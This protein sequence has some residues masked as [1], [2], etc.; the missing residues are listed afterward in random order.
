MKLG[1]E[2][3]VKPRNELDDTG[4]N[5]QH[6]G[7]QHDNPDDEGETA[8]PPKKVSARLTIAIAQ[9]V[10]NASAEAQAA[11]HTATRANAL[12]QALASPDGQVQIIGPDSLTLGDDLN[13]DEPDV[14]PGRPPMGSLPLQGLL[15]DG[16]MIPATMADVQRHLQALGVRPGEAPPVHPHPGGT[17]IGTSNDGGLTVPGRSINCLLWAPSVH[18]TY[19]G[20]PSVA[21]ANGLSVGH[22]AAV[23]QA[24]AGAPFG[25]SDPTQGL[26]EVEER[27]R[28]ALTGDADA[29]PMAFVAVVDPRD[30]N[31]AHM[32]AVFVRREAHP[33]NPGETQIVF[34]YADHGS[35]T[36][37]PNRPDIDPNSEISSIIFDHT[38]AVVQPD[39]ETRKDSQLA[40][41]LVAGRPTGDG[42]ASLLAQVTTLLAPDTTA[43]GRRKALDAI[44]DGLRAMGLE[45]GGTPVRW[46]NF[47][48]LATSANPDAE[49]FLQLIQE[50]DWRA[51][52]ERALGAS[53]DVAQAFT[54]VPTQS[55]ART[56]AL[57]TIFA[58]NAA[59]TY[60]GDP[61]TVAFVSA[62][63]QNDFQFQTQPDVS[64]DGNEVHITFEEMWPR[65]VRVEYGLLPGDT[66]VELLLDGDEFRLVL[67]HGLKL[68]DVAVQARLR[69]MIA[70]E[71]TRVRHGETEYR[72]NRPDV[73][74]D[75][76]DV[77]QDF[78]YRAVSDI[79]QA[80]AAN[81]PDGASTVR[82]DRVAAHRLA[83]AARAENDRMMR[84][85]LAAVAIDPDLA[86]VVARLLATE[87]TSGAARSIARL[88]GDLTFPSGRGRTAQRQRTRTAQLL[89]ASLR[90]AGEH[91]ANELSQ[92]PGDNELASI[93]D[94]AV[95]R[96][97]FIRNAAQARM[98]AQ[99][100][101]PRGVLPTS[102][103]D[104]TSTFVAEATQNR[105]E[106]LDELDRRRSEAAE[107]QAEPSEVVL[108]GLRGSGATLDASLRSAIIAAAARLGF[109]APGREAAMLAQL[110]GALAALGG[111]TGDPSTT[112][113]VDAARAIIRDTLA[114][115]DRVS[116]ADRA[117]GDAD[118][119]FQRQI[120]DA[121]GNAQVVA[122]T[123]HVLRSLEH[124]VAYVSQVQLTSS[125]AE[126]FGRPTTGETPRRV[127]VTTQRL[128]HRPT[129]VG[130]DLGLTTP[131]SAEAAVQAAVTQVASALGLSVVEVGHGNTYEITLPGGT[132]PIRVHVRA[133]GVRGNAAAEVRPPRGRSGTWE[134]RVATAEV[135]RTGLVLGVAEALG[136]TVATYLDQTT[137]RPDPEQARRI[138]LAAR[139][140]VVAAARTATPP[141]T[142]NP[143][144]DRL[145]AEA[146]SLIEDLG[147]RLD[148]PGYGARRAEIATLLSQVFGPSAAT[149]VDDL[150][151]ELG[152]PAAALTD[153]RENQHAEAARRATE[154]R[155]E[156]QAITDIL[157]DQ[158]QSGLVTGLPALTQLQAT[159]PALT[160][161]ELAAHLA[162]TLASIERGL[163][164]TAH[165]Q[166]GS[167]TFVTVTHSA[168]SGPI[169]V[170]VQ[171]GV[172][173]AGTG[174]HLSIDLGTRTVTIIVAEGTTADVS[175]LHLVGAL[176]QAVETVARSDNGKHTRPADVLGR[177]PLTRRSRRELDGVSPADV[178]LA[179][180][181]EFQA[182]L[183]IADPQSHAHQRNLLILLARAGVTP[184]DAGHQARQAVLRNLLQHNLAQR[185]DAMLSRPDNV[186]E[187]VREALL[188]D[189][190]NA[191]TPTVSQGRRG[192]RVVIPAAAESTGSLSTP[193]HKPLHPFVARRL[194]PRRA[195]RFERRVAASRFWVDRL[196]T[197]RMNDWPSRTL[198]HAARTA[199][200]VPKFIVKRTLSLFTTKVRHQRPWRVFA[201]SSVSGV[202]RVQLPD[203]TKRFVWYT[204]TTAS[205]AVNRLGG[206]RFSSYTGVPEKGPRPGEHRPGPDGPPPIV[207]F[208][209]SGRIGLD[210]LNALASFLQHWVPFT[211]FSVKNSSGIGTPMPIGNSDSEAG[212]TV[213]RA[214]VVGNGG[215]VVRSNPSHEQSHR[216]S[217]TLYVFVGT[218]INVSIRLPNG[219]VKS[220]YLW[221]GGQGTPV[222]GSFDYDKIMAEVNKFLEAYRDERA[223]ADPVRAAWR[224][225][226][227]LVRHFR[228]AGLD[229][230]W[231]IQ[232]LVF[233]A[234]YSH[235][236]L[237]MG[238]LPSSV[239]DDIEPHGPFTQTN[240]QI[241]VQTNPN[242]SASVMAVSL[243]WLG[244]ILASPFRPIST[245]RAIRA[246]FGRSVFRSWVVRQ[247]VG[248]FLDPASLTPTV[249]PE[250]A[251]PGSDPDLELDV[252]LSPDEVADLADRYRVLHH[253]R[254]RGLALASEMARIEALAE[255]SPEL[256]AALEAAR[257][258]PPLPAAAPPTTLGPDPVAVLL[259]GGQVAP[260]ST[261]DTQRHLQNLGV[262]PGD[263]P[264][265]HPHPG[266]TWL[267]TSNDG[268]LTVPGRSD[269]CLTWLVSAYHTYFG[270][271]S[272]AP[273]NLTGQGFA[274]RILET[275]A[276][277][278]FQAQPDGVQ[279]LA[280]IEEHLRQTLPPDAE[281]GPMA[282]VIVADPRDRTAAHGY[283]VFARREADPDNPGQTKIVFYYA[284]H[285]ST[286]GDV[287]RPPID[288]DAKIY[289]MIFD[290]TGTAVQAPATTR[291][292][293]RRLDH[294]LVAG[295]PDATG[296]RTLVRHIRTLLST[297]DTPPAAVL[298]DLERQ[299]GDMGLEPGGTHRRWRRLAGLTTGS[300]PDVDAFLTLMREPAW[301]AAYL[302]ALDTPDEV[303]KVLTGLP[304]GDPQLRI[305]LAAI[306]AADP[307]P[308]YAGRTDR[309]AIDLV[310]QLVAGD[311]R[312][313]HPTTAAVSGNEVQLAT[314]PTV[315]RTVRVE[316]AVLPPG[317]HTRLSW[318][319]DTRTFRLAI[320]HDLDVTTPEA[321][322]RIARELARVQL[323]GA[324]FRSEHSAADDMFLDVLQA[325]SYVGIADVGH[326]LAANRPPGLTGAEG[327]T[328]AAARLVQRSRAEA[329]RVLRVLLAAVAVDPAAAAT[330]VRL[331][332]ADATNGDQPGRH[333][334][335]LVGDLDLPPGHR[336]GV[337][338][339]RQ[340]VG[341]LVAATLAVARADLDRALT[342]QV[343]E[344]ELPSIVVA[345]IDHAL[346]VRFAAHARLATPGVSRDSVLSA[347]TATF[348][349]TFLT[350]AEARRAAILASLA[351]RPNSPDAVTLPRLAGT[352]GALDLALQAALRAEAAT[353]GF[354][355]PSREAAVL[356]RWGPDL[357]RLG[358]RGANPSVD[359]HVEA[360][361]DLVR[362][363][364]AD[365]DRVSIQDGPNG[366]ALVL[367]QKRFTGP[368]GRTRV[369]EVTIHVHRFLADRAAYIADVQVATDMRIDFGRPMSGSPPRRVLVRTLL[370]DR[371]HVDDSADDLIAHNLDQTTQ[372]ARAALLQAA[373][374]LAVTLTEDGDG[375]RLTW[376]TGEGPTRVVLTVAPTRG[377]SIAEVRP[378]RP[379]SET[380]VI[381][382]PPS[383]MT[384]T[385][386][387]LDLAEALG[388]ALGQHLALAAGTPSAHKPT[389]I[390]RAARL[391]AVAT[392]LVTAS[393]MPSAW[394]TR[395]RAARLAA[396]AHTLIE[397]LG[398]RQDQP[399]HVARRTELT[400]L[401]TELFGDD[402][403]TRV[404]S[405]LSELG[406]AVEDLTDPTQRAYAEAARRRARATERGR[407]I[408]DILLERHRPGL[409]A[410]VATLSDL[411]TAGSPVTGEGLA[412]RLF[413][414]TRDILLSRGLTVEAHRRL[415]GDTVVTV[416]HDGLTGPVT[417]TVRSSPLAAGTAAHLRVDP[418]SRTVVITVAEGM[419]APN[420]LLHL[421][422]AL[423]QALET[424]ARTDHDR[425]TAPADV[426]GDHKLT[427]ALRRDTDGLS[428]ADMALVAQIQRQA[429]QLDADTRP[430]VLA[431]L[432][433]LLHRAGVRDGQQHSTL[434]RRLLL[435]ALPPSTARLVEA[436]L[437]QDSRLTAQLR[438]TLPGQLGVPTPTRSVGRRVFTVARLPTLGLESS[439]SLS[440]PPHQ[441]LQP[442]VRRIAGR[443]ATRLER[444][445]AA[446]RF[447]INRMGSD[448]IDA[449]SSPVA[450]AL[451][452]SILWPVKFVRGR[453][454]ALLTGK[455]R[456]Q[457]PWRVFAFSNTTAYSRLRLPDGSHT[458]VAYTKTTATRAVNRLGAIR[459]STFTPWK[460]NADPQHGHDNPYGPTGVPPGYLFPLTGR[461]WMD[462]IASILN[463]LPLISV[464]AENGSGIGTPFP[465]GN[466]DAETRPT[467]VRSLANLGD[468][469]TGF[470]GRS[471]PS[472]TLS[473]THSFTSYAFIG[474]FLDVKIGGVKQFYIWIGGQGL[475]VS[476][477]EQYDK[478]MS[479]LAEI[480]QDAQSR[481]RGLRGLVR[482]FRSINRYRKIFADAGMEFQPFVL[483][484]G[485]SHRYTPYLDAPDELG[486]DVENVHGD[487]DNWHGPF[488]QGNDRAGLQTNP[489]VAIFV[490][491]FS[492]RR[493]LRFLL[494]PVNPKAYARGARR[495][496]TWVQRPDLD[497]TLG[498]STAPPALSAGQS[499]A[500][501]STRLPDAVN[502]ALRDR[503][504]ELLTARPRTPAEANELDGLLRLAATNRRL[505]HLFEQ[506]RNRLAGGPSRQPRGPNN[507]GGQAPGNPGPGNLGGPTGGS[508][509]NPGPRT[510]AAEA[511]RRQALGMDPATGKFRQ[512]EAETARRIEE[513][514]GIELERS[515][516]PN[517]DWVD[518]VSG[519][520]YD[521]VGN[522]DAAYFDRQWPNLQIRIIDHLLKADRVPIDV[523]RFTPEQIATVQQFLTDN[524]LGPRAFLVGD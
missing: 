295:R 165:G 358:G 240:D 191:P 389:T 382:V 148:Q 38:G 157:L 456:Y 412:R 214:H 347:T 53:A 445:I 144:S 494:N 142:V 45:P 376:P 521:A 422:G 291:T 408:N 30:T 508:P 85:L 6:E 280:E 313:E 161:A 320:A 49:L 64:F 476:G 163:T 411:L 305:A 101:D 220:F 125:F 492:P 20:H 1:D 118:L 443:R 388:M 254:V 50:P 454:W 423:T 418:E 276:G 184:L 39:T 239:G 82:A 94:E 410:D 56:I 96:A 436:L 409:T 421:A 217:A 25:T 489:N 245:V 357:H 300:T 439:G 512:A 369:V 173:P 17:W 232:P 18:S 169:S 379:G 41:T 106:I 100:A 405:A 59:P 336:R 5:D 360:E 88:T 58:T 273:A 303:A 190:V 398:L 177:H 279:G 10:L 237:P 172:L 510:A 54:G 309:E 250:A 147:L 522:F 368:D 514:L 316:Y 23:L 27:L 253:T 104:F 264:P 71:L 26:A 363:T 200:W 470:V 523:S 252:Q 361:R 403:A 502:R 359:D 181:I 491:A 198:A 180:Q 242:V 278:A 149:T 114:R 402:A 297:P 93:L 480:R 231:T 447:K 344:N 152:R 234:G 446:R 103:A 176:A 60:A 465:F 29:G 396:E 455:V 486:W 132:G 73:R 139:L 183:L 87:A 32:Y 266:G 511:A 205:K 36:A 21:P 145:S 407:L 458:W 434:R 61:A 392:A 2:P 404:E 452:R 257:N 249:A 490:G 79:G 391:A 322:V 86:P 307:A 333:L 97:L 384:H 442:T 102:K 356:A 140:A 224:L 8:G 14:P 427:R 270:R 417:I 209:E 413:T 37:E 274:A 397:G 77:L 175:S 471:E 317:E 226:K 372:H 314:S 72:S 153:P 63:A 133:G 138:A 24:W 43:I 435:Q 430:M 399:E 208:P 202:T 185:I 466:K 192:F 406:G 179:A 506:A 497:E 277:T 293:G 311:F 178:G 330:I 286:T 416:R 164:L 310:T 19:Y 355:D 263:R 212:R 12:A 76:Y 500:T 158:Q 66:E 168:L 246:G 371:V 328:A 302:R 136:L 496:R 381:Q 464:S 327:D 299:L 121:Q 75:Y 444:R 62:I 109:A 123:V 488:T 290:Q 151:T 432:M 16:A 4:E 451:S 131:A 207:L 431:N 260:P 90:I 329:D 304:D 453:P 462:T 463:A 130:D 326:V 425:Q 420:V 509:G 331:L 375:Y 482:L 367:F 485:Y 467:T 46:S 28:Q 199:L 441:A 228:D 119:L 516:N 3:E 162:A 433:I 424:I 296:A 47:R 108:P 268:G 154:Q 505:N 225:R 9:L 117:S 70:H 55:A 40:Y 469:V 518:P 129:D 187:R 478:L 271:P 229:L 204:K 282:F 342:G 107:G 487:D 141:G 238:D 438:G 507:P 475:V 473:Q 219:E 437:A 13:S 383:R 206:L 112:D 377:S 481:P 349:A 374:A 91:L 498:L 335:R 235:R 515:T 323:G 99:N 457:R 166:D 222:S 81:R 67:R 265:L 230:N 288:P 203:G 366:D 155:A 84:L 479:D 210:A 113:I 261:V 110:G 34:Y 474:T 334:A 352:G 150:L 196:L 428:P 461:V 124:R 351:G 484:V 22:P 171:P 283:A 419:T 267:N 325:Y 415:G 346:F 287:N 385:G 128:A 332:A 65:T 216:V 74:E 393:P 341:Q 146:H 258:Q 292:S 298:A 7:D 429:G 33:T 11:A 127:R 519:L 449:M 364:L 122:V 159:G 401:T 95:D 134:V 186:W 78:S 354:P 213:V 223:T 281:A 135:S 189:T 170:R 345:A 337:D 156:R 426:L 503:Y 524:G 116:L 68:S 111:L 440:T 294:A 215:T 350:D 340:Q 15:P 501:A 137:G 182:K 248:Q 174:A 321:Q 520:T 256:R 378:P 468:G 244:R 499:T 218:F 195:R 221:L 52:Y 493:L 472:G 513:L 251:R 120:T 160:G 194:G 365:P 236:Y 362:R 57:A 35:T 247:D 243:K 395:A 80:L 42:K 504:R 211:T 83:E 318:D 315:S 259:A 339:K 387:P 188:P 308:A 31:A 92:Q 495:I 262:R 126:D 380:W 289:S 201:V 285:G 353:L 343:A 255:V 319:A 370:T 193:P 89:A 459:F 517:V 394:T 115:P 450:A 448:R 48:K 324:D 98:N 284:D 143:R 390:A 51:A 272:V 477:S 269:N 275:W 44:E 460:D 348:D 197:D 241:G 400:R 306:F 312:F 105:Q 414:G 373:T 483:E 338:E 227:A 386:L 167:T 233:E 69:V 301:R